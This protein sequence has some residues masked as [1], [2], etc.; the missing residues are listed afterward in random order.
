M[1]YDEN[2]IAVRWENVPQVTLDEYNAK[3]KENKEA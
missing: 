2:G 1:G 3:N